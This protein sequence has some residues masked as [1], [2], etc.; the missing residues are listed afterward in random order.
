[1]GDGYVTEVGGQRLAPTRSCSRHTPA[2]RHRLRRA[3]QF[4]IPFPIRCPQMHTE[5][6]EPDTVSG[7]TR[8]PVPSPTGPTSTTKCRETLHQLYDCADCGPPPPT[9]S[10]CHQFTRPCAQPGAD[11]SDILTFPQGLT[12]IHAGRAENRVGATNTARES[13]TQTFASGA[14]TRRRKSH[15]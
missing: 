6:K 8:T 15:M 12:R 1:M 4:P 5:D 14:N 3:R 9:A 13:Q 2:S 11:S 10:D 7:Q